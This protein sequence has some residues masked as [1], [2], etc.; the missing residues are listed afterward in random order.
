MIK[1]KDNNNNDTN[2]NTNNSHTTTLI[3]IIILLLLIIIITTI[4][5]D[6]ISL[7]VY[8]CILDVRRLLLDNGRNKGLYMFYVCV[9]RRVLRR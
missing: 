5:T 9:R 4:S 1:Y 2:A 6:D 3:L 8:V 7:C